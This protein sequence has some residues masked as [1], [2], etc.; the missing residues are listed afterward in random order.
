MLRVAITA[1]QPLR[2]SPLSASRSR[3]C[4]RTPSAA[5]IQRQLIIH[6]LLPHMVPRIAPLPLTPLR[7]RLHYRA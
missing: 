7:A 3:A 6:I 5:L 2:A 1:L 4:A